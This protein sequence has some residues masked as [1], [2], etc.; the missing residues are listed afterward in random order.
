MATKAK[1]ATTT[2]PKKQLIDKSYRLRNMHPLTFELKSGDNKRLTIFDEK[3][4]RQ[5]A[6]RHCP[7]ETSIFVDEQQDD[8]IVE[9]IVFIQGL[10]NTGHTDVMTQEFLDNHPS[11]GGIFE[12]IDDERDAAEMADME[13]VILDIKHA[14]RSKIKEDNGITQL[15]VVLSAVT[16]DLAGVS[17]MS[18]P[19]LKM[20]AYEV[21]ENN[22]RRF[23]NDEGEVTM[24]DDQTFVR[25]AIAQEAFN[26]GILTLSPDTSKV[27]WGDNKGVVTPVPTG[28]QYLTFFADFL[29]TEEGIEVTKEI[30]KRL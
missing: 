13:D 11:N 7:Y 5:R 8:S 17:K 20:K 9:P 12:V 27:L 26:A 28:K 18:V 22:P 24:F 25:S 15:R 30:K 19:E 23:I 6:I 14:V 2:R 21:V 29:S 3:E 1:P 4:K 10:Y 16:S